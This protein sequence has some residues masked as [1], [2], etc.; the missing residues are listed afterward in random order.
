M[1]CR[2]PLD[3]AEESLVPFELTSVGQ[4]CPLLT[5]M[6]DRRWFTHEME[7]EKKSCIMEKKGSSFLLANIPL[8]MKRKW[9][10]LFYR[11]VN[12]EI[13]TFNKLTEEK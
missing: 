4:V 12:T 10:T 7:E 11:E 3:A 1:G 6:K 8:C 13:L 2:L 9:Q 5:Q